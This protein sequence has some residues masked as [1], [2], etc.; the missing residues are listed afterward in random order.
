MKLKFYFKKHP[1]LI[2]ILLKLHKI[3]M[4]CS[5]FIEKLIVGKI[6][7]EEMIKNKDWTVDRLEMF[8]IIKLETDKRS[9]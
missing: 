3:K 8:G 7:K 5:Y 6:Q 2:T 4:G 9:K 1:T